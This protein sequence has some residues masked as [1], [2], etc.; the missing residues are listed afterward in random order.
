MNFAVT[1]RNSWIGHLFC[2]TI[3]VY[4]GVPTRYSLFFFDLDKKN[5]YKYKSRMY[6]ATAEE[7]DAFLTAYVKKYPK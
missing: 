5:R 7:L 6:F 4:P 2:P 3:K 1:T